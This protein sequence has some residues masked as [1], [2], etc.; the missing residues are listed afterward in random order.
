MAQ[1]STSPVKTTKAL[2]DYVLLG[3]SGL[4]VSP[5]CLGAMTFG[6]QWGIGT[7][8]EESKKVFDLYYEKGGNFFDTANMYNFGDSERF[9]GDYVSDKRSDVVIATKYSCNPTALQKDKRFNPNFGGNHRK[10][11]V[12]NLD[13]SLKRLNMSY[14]DILYVHFFEYRT[15]I[16][17]Y[18][19]SLDDIVRSGKA[20]YVAVSDTPSWALSRSNTIA[21][22]RGWSPFIGLQTRYNL[23]DR[24]M[25]FDLQPACAEHDIGI[26][27]WGI[28]AEGFLTGKYTRESVNSDSRGQSIA[29]HAQ[30][31][32]NWKILD[33][34]TAIS[35][36]IDRSP[37]QIALN[38][39]QQ[40]PGI[41]SP[42]I[43]AKTVTQLEENLKSLEFK[44]TP[45]QM[46]RL[47]DVSQPTELPFPYSFTDQFDKYV[48][49]NIEVPNKFGSIAT[50]RNYG[51]LY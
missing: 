19:R 4:R 39:I 33:E 2:D 28:I 1:D 36:E 45:E 9:L 22:L 23:L 13:E 16:E 26:I 47:D 3:R 32:K 10:S 31:E 42:L 17:E 38:W 30:S 34:V 18:M 46:K 37:V 7:N 27:P 21:E 40:K 5:L 50:S 43:G 24:S 51:R 12:E 8:K 29:K 44:L 25:E 48:G 49:K 20:L 14:V 41:T 6:E 11:L 15:P 35:K